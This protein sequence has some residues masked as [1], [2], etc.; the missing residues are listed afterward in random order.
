MAITPISDIDSA[1][2]HGQLYTCQRCGEPATLL[3]GDDN[4]CVSCHYDHTPSRPRDR[5][6]TGQVKR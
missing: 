6:N 1:V 5:P 4:E 3:Y 2:V